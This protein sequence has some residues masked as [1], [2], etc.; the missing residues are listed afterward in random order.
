MNDDVMKKSLWRRRILFAARAAIKAG[1]KSHKLRTLMATSN[2][3]S[4]ILK[5]FIWLLR[6][7]ADCVRTGYTNDD[8][9]GVFDG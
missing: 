6:P 4:Y 8:D 3:S 1:E 2:S 5:L 9:D 7:L